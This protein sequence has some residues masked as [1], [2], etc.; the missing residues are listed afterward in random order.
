MSLHPVL[1]GGAWRPSA[2]P[3]GSFAAVNPA[4]RDPIE[5]LYPVS[6]LDEVLEA[7]EAGRRAAV[8][9]RSL[10]DR[11]DRIAACLEDYASRIEAA[12]D[13]LC[14]MAHLE[15]AYPITPRLKTVE[16]PRT[17][18]QLRQ[19]ATAAKDR[20]WTH[21]TIDT[22]AGIRSYYGALGGPVVVFGPNNFP[23]AFN[24]IAGGDFVA[25]VA[26]G[27]PVIGKA[28]TGHPG[29]S[30]LLA[31]LAAA[32]A[33]A[34]GLPDGMIQLVY[35]TPPDVGLALVSHPAVAAT[36]FTGSKDAGLKLKAAA[37]AAGKP[38][39]LEMSS[40]NP[41]FVL[42]GAL[43]ERGAAIAKELLDSCALG[44]GQ[45]CTRPGLTIVPASHAASFIETVSAHFTAAAPGVLLG[46]S[47]VSG[48]E[49]GLTELTTSGATVVVGGHRAEGEGFRFQPTLLRA[50]GDA[51]L[52]HPHALQ[53]EAFGTVNTI[54][55]ARDRAQM[56]AIAGELEGNLTGS[57]YSD[58]NGSDDDAYAELEPALRG[59]VGR[60]LNDK[61]P[62]GVAV[63][64]AMNHGGPFPATGHPGFTAVGIPASLLR[65]AALQSYD[66]VR[67]H[68]LPPEL[69]DKNPTGTMWRSIDGTWRQGDL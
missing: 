37:D 26:A 11:A 68:R 25:A 69:Q 10:P 36:G 13:A 64:P 38:I 59:R 29:T 61:M 49:H 9:L 48:I 34:A 56:I 19:A 35:R 52:E 12:A 67:A 50:S 17:T 3:A 47:G 46:A 22:K 28:N 45:F 53:S 14:E 65:F 21:A 18:N 27:K 15:T 24:S 23:F 39:Y 62:T 5:G 2:R 43:D 66:A 4:T 1:V 42:P 58:T 31:E 40:V 16:L 6:S 7:C 54:V 51:F 55:V 60:L 20:S 44:A 63:S 57:I 33:R 32:A 30:R 8:A 41:I